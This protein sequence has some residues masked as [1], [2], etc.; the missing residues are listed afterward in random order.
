[1]KKTI[2]FLGGLFLAVA[3]FAE[4][5]PGKEI[6][7]GAL[8]FGKKISYAAKVEYS[9]PA[10]RRVNGKFAYLV[11]RDGSVCRRLDL[12]SGETYLQNDTGQYGIT[13]A[14]VARIDEASPLW[15]WDSLYLEV[16][17]KEIEESSFS[18]REVDYCQKP[19][20][21]VTMTLPE[22]IFLS[23][24]TG[25]PANRLSDP[26]DAF[27]SRYAYTRTFLIDRDS[28]QIYARKHYNSRGE[29]IFNR[30]IGSIENRE[31]P[32]SKLFE[33]PEKIT[34]HVLFFRNFQ[35]LV[36]QHS[37][38]VSSGSR[39]TGGLPGRNWMNWPL[40]YGMWFAFG[41]AVVAAAGVVSLKYRKQR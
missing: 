40:N 30:E 23:S 31:K 33:T 3:V 38:A 36:E 27:F 11:N 5:P 18:V 26:K 32:D 4:E 19:C 10:G 16:P 15:Y 37:A 12:D 39:S 8:Q 22:A 20:Y 7:T 35:E 24:V 6:L 17:T 2:I 28:K 1:M 14:V 34:A 25:Y 41:V 29:L 21:E 13:P 9:D